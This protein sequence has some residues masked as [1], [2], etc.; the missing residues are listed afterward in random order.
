MMF[1]LVELGFEVR[2]FQTHCLSELFTDSQNLSLTRQSVDDRRR[3]RK[4]A[5]DKAESLQDVRFGIE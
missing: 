4:V 5:R 1:D 3:V 2:R